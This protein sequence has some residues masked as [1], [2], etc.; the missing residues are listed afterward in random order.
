MKSFKQFRNP[1]TQLKKEIKRND[2]LQKIQHLQQVKCKNETIKR[3]IFLLTRSCADLVDRNNA[4]DIPA[5]LQKI[6]QN[7]T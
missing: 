1:A 6:V 4:L 7:E 5:H 3:Q 2:D